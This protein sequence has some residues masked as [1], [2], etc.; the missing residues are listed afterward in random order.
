MRNKVARGATLVLVLALALGLPAGLPGL[1]PLSMPAKAWAQPALLPGTLAPIGSAQVGLAAVGP[2]AAL[3]SIMPMAAAGFTRVG[4]TDFAQHPGGAG[5]GVAVEYRPAE[6][7]SGVATL[8][9]YGH[10]QP[11]EGP[12]S[13]PVQQELNAA[14]ADIRAV[15]PLRRYGVANAG[16]TAP[17]TL[18]DGTPALRCVAMLL[19]YEGGV[20]AADSLVCLGVVR[21]QFLKLRVTL[22]TERQGETLPRAITLGRVLVAALAAGIP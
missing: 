6:G 12:G 20:R 2:A 8:Y 22:P 5:L 3:A 11:V 16:E 1:L 13:P 4:F 17:V 9:Q 14:L 21:G 10:N 18:P 15:A 19:A 7:G